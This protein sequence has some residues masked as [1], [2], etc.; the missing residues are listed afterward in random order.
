MPFETADEAAAVA[1]EQVREYETVADDQQLAA[2]AEEFPYLAE[3]VAGRVAK[4]G[5]DFAQ[6]FEYGLDLI[7]DARE[8]RRDKP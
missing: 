7:L 6:A 3:V 1:Q 5:H 4:V 2:L 8:Q